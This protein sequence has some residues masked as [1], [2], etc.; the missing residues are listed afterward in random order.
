MRFYEVVVGS[1]SGPQRH[2]RVASPTDAQAADAAAPLMRAHEAILSIRESP[3]D[4]LQQADA[5]PPKTQAEEMA[6]STPGMAAKS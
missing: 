1:D 5:P 6:P 4:G 3:D 2:L